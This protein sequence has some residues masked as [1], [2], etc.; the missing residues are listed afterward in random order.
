MGSPDS[1][2]YIGSS[3]TVAASALVGYIDDPR[4]YL[5]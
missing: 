5:S 4:P 3:A 1:I 2:V